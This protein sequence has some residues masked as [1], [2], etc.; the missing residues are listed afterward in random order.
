[1]SNRI[2]ICSSCGSELPSEEAIC[3]KC[4]IALAVPKENIQEGKYICPSCACRFNEPNSVLYP[5]HT[6]WY[7]PKKGYRL[8]CPHC[9]SLIK[10]CLSK[11]LTQTEKMI[12]TS[13][14]LLSIFLPGKPYSGAV[15][16]LI[17]I[18]VTFSRKQR[19]ML[20]VKSEE[21]RYALENKST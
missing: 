10:D 2:A 14:I 18:I 13:L 19:A 5:S 17:F 21:T 3:Q 16:V 9:G 8:Q 11:E 7:F 4:D 20:S 15:L 6:A 1:M 12:A